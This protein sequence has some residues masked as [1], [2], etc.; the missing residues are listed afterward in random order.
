MLQSETY[1]IF[2]DLGV[3]IA[4]CVLLSVIMI[5]SPI[6]QWLPYLAIASLVVPFI[7][8]YTWSVAYWKIDS[9]MGI[10]VIT[11]LSTGSVEF[12]AIAIIAVALIMLLI[13][14]TMLFRWL[15]KAT[16]EL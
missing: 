10:I 2:Y 14:I 8:H 7:R 5:G 4:G 11:V 3:R 6:V 1:S 16:A 12:G 13:L 15:V 9:L